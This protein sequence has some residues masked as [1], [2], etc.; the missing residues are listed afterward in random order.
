MYHALPYFSNLK[1]ALIIDFSD[2]EL[3]YTCET[4]HFKKGEGI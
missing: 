2:P 3:R 4:T 1:R